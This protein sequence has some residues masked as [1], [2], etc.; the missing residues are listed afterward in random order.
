M[1]IRDRWYTAG[2]LLSFMLVGAIALTLRAAGQAMGWGFQL[3]QPLVIGALVYVMFAVGLSLS[4][5]HI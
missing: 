1:C 3:Q 4:L 2:V 5:I